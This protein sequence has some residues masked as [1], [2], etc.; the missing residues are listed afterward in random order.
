MTNL[1]KFFWF[2]FQKIPHVWVRIR[3][4]FGLNPGIPDFEKLYCFTWVS[5]HTSLMNALAVFHFYGAKSGNNYETLR[6]TFRHWRRSKLDNDDDGWVC[7]WKHNTNVETWTSRHQQFRGRWKRVS[8]WLVS[9]F[10]TFFSF[11]FNRKISRALNLFL[12][13]P[14][15]LL[16]EFFMKQNLCVVNLNGFYVE[17]RNGMNQYLQSLRSFRGRSSF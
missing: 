10:S 8:L 9:S 14:R 2:C 5:W 15:E 11:S 16:V 7:W 13:S 12:G 17:F 3:D 1:N 6:Q 4:I